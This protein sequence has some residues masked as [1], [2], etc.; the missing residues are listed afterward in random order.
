MN[1]P[2]DGLVV[3]LEHAAPR[4]AAAGDGEVADTRGARGQHDL[5]SQGQEIS[6]ETVSRKYLFT[7]SPPPVTTGKLPAG[8]VPDTRRPLLRCRSSVALSHCHLT[9]QTCVPCPH[10]SSTGSA[11]T[12]CSLTGATASKAALVGANTVK[13]PGSVSSVIRPASCGPIRGEQLSTNH[14][15]P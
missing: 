14:S 9:R 6:T 15:S 4:V 5:R 10:L 11:S 13:G 3:H 7:S 1:D 2:V 12:A 8:K